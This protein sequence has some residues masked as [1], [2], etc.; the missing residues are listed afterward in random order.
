MRI[1]GTNPL[2]ALIEA[3]QQNENSDAAERQRVDQSSK[4]QDR[5]EFSTDSRNIRP[6][7]ERANEA[8]DVRT[9]RVAE[10]SRQLESGTYNINAE[11]VADALITGSIVNTEA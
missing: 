11:R 2:H 1:D 5:L 6:L 3:Q 9:D 7:V 8:P 10:I 4:D